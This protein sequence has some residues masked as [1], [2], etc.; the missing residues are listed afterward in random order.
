M[1][2]LGKC[3]FDVKAII[4]YVSQSALDYPGF[5]WC[6][7]EGGGAIPRSSARWLDAVTERQLP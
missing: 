6:Q 5:L 4:A 1:G 2:F 7:V 3:S